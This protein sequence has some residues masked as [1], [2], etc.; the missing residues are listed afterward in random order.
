MNKPMQPRVRNKTDS[1][2]P[3][4]WERS[5]ETH[6]GRPETELWFAGV[7][8]DISEKAPKERVDTR[9]TQSL[10]VNANRQ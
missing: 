8:V 7:G 5:L 1:A 9:D 4:Y 3:K 10:V 6:H 2:R